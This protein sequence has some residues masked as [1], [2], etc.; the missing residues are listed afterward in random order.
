MKQNYSYYDIFIILM[1]TE[2]SKVCALG[3]FEIIDYLNA[4]HAPGK[5]HSITHVHA[6]LFYLFLTLFP[7][8]TYSCHT[9]ILFSCD[10]IIRK[11]TDFSYI[12]NSL[13]NYAL[14]ENSNKRICFTVG[15]EP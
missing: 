8:F 7:F 15:R 2:A 4:L 1:W 13:A 6:K 3:N 10:F 5:A 11:T 14:F 12:I 9:I